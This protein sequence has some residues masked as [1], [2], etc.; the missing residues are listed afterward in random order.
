[1]PAS[2]SLAIVQHLDST[3]S[4]LD[5]LPF[6]SPDICDTV[7][8]YINQDSPTPISSALKW[9]E[10]YASDSST[11]AI[12]TGLSNHYSKTWSAHKFILINKFYHQKLK[13]GEIE[14]FHGKLIHNK[15]IFPDSKFIALIIVPSSIRQA[16][17]DYYHSGS[18]G[19]HMGEYKTSFHLASLCNDIKSMLNSCAHCQAY[20]SWRS[21][22]L[23]V[24]F[25]W[26]VT[27]PFYIMHCYLWSPGHLS[28]S[29]SKG[30]HL[31]NCMCDLSTFI[32]SS[33]TND[34]RAEP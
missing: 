4:F 29:S 27:T 32:V 3:D 20:N 11:N 34:T 5:T 22:C 28:S 24:H 2:S 17:F 19:G 21:C 6:A 13:N 26:P 25:S 14:L 30:I 15:C 1:M 16:I 10:A 33:V 31:L 7:P 18:L 9:T 12:I 23:E 8:C